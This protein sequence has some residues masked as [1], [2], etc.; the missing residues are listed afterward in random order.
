MP[1][2][3]AP[4]PAAKP[5]DEKLSAPARAMRKL[6][7]LR[8][9]DLALHLPLRYVD[10][11]RL[12]PIGRL[13]DGDSAQVQGTVLECRVETRTRRQLLVRIDDGSGVSAPTAW[14]SGCTISRPAKP[15]RTSP[16]T[17][18]SCPAASVFKCDG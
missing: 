8:D 5:P 9:I 1:T 13:R 2:S 4:A 12:E 14:N 3:L 7:L 17:R 16:R 6:G 18:T 10:E 15:A 11:T